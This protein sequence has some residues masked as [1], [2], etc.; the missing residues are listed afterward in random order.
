MSDAD[1]LESTQQ[2]GVGALDCSW[3][4]VWAAIWDRGDTD[5]T[6]LETKAMPE[7]KDGSDIGHRDWNAGWKVCWKSPL[8][9][10]IVPIKFARKIDAKI[11][12]EAANNE[13]HWG[14][15]MRS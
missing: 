9:E 10:W 13:Q 1:D 7:S 14:Q 5:E 4:G 2:A 8:A 6:I 12:A 11:A 3:V 15:P